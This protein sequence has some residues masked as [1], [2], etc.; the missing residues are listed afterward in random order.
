MADLSD[1]IP[2]RHRKKAPRSPRYSTLEPLAR[3]LERFRLERRLT[4]R[5]LAKRAGISANHYQDISKA[6]TNPTLGV[7]MHLAEA[8]GVTVPRLLDDCDAKVPEGA[9][10]V[11]ESDLRKLSEV[12]KQFADAVSRLVGSDEK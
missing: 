8:L 9:C 4:Q 6:N 5:A 12:S 10:V 1:G 3:T 11:S 7:L 2:R